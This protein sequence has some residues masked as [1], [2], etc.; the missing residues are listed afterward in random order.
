MEGVS[1][2]RTLWRS[3]SL[4]LAVATARGSCLKS[5]SSLSSPPDL[6]GGL[7]P[8]AFLVMPRSMPRSMPSPWK[9]RMTPASRDV[10][11][12]R[13]VMGESRVSAIIQPMGSERRVFSDL[14]ARQCK[15]WRPA[16]HSKFSR[17]DTRNGQTHGHSRGPQR[18]L[19]HTRGAAAPGL[20]PQRCER[21]RRQPRVRR[22]KARCFRLV[23]WRHTI[24]V[25]DCSKR[26]N[27]GENRSTLHFRQRD[28][29]KTPPDRYTATMQD[30]GFM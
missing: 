1:T 29:I 21:S 15:N 27:R 16:V 26:P 3:K 19:Q 12:P 28:C 10:G 22:R 8:G 9:A 24:L 25:Q 30:G 20:R 23:I 7:R 5:R 14:K 11:G 17:E 13:V 18:P 6:A 2:S 4:R